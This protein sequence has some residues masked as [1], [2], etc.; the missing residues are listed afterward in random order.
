LFEPGRIAW[1]K[2]LEHSSKVQ[3]RQS[4]GSRVA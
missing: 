2:S 1:D 4:I 3:I